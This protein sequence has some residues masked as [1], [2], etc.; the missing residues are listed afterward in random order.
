[1]V[2]GQIFE[3]LQKLIKN[4]I[5]I[6][7]SSNLINNIRTCICIR[8]CNRNHSY[9]FLMQYNTIWYY[10]TDLPLVSFAIVCRKHS[11]SLNINTHINEQTY[12]HTISLSSCLI[13]YAV[14][15]PIEWKGFL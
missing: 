6:R 2:L 9:P 13:C 3:Q 14:Y 10:T 12:Q 5:Y 8:K 4:P 1:M 11:D 7:I 15:M